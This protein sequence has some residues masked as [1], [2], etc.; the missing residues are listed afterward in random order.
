MK[1]ITMN[2][3]SRA[4]ARQVKADFSESNAKIIDNGAGSEC[5]WQVVYE[6]PESKLS[7]SD[8]TALLREAFEVMDAVPA[9]NEQREILSFPGVIKK[10]KPVYMRINGTGKQVEVKIKRSHKIER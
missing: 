8:V 9:E 4:E 5:R 6:A 1:T 3:K 10:K 2:C 7:N